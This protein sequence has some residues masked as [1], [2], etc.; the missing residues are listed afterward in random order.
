MEQKWQCHRERGAGCKSRLSLWAE[1]R[2]LM[3]STDLHTRSGASVAAQLSLPPHCSGSAW[4]LWLGKLWSFFIGKP[5]HGW[6]KQKYSLVSIFMLYTVR[7]KVYLLFEQQSEVTLWSHCGTQMSP[8]MPQALLDH[9]GVSTFNTPPGGWI[10]QQ[11]SILASAKAIRNI[12]LS[13]WFQYSCSFILK[14]YYKRCYS[15]QSSG[16]KQN[17]VLQGEACCIRQTQTLHHPQKT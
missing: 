12:W 10:L 3:G 17:Q 4:L 11:K 5:Q 16:A 1:V 15:L 8:E 9:Y 7:K 14:R 13:L 2:L 6:E